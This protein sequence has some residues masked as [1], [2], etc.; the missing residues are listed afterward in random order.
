MLAWIDYYKA[1]EETA[2]RSISYYTKGHLASFCL[3]LELRERSDQ[4]AS[5]QDVMRALWSEY[6]RVGRGIP[7]GAFPGIV[8]R[9]TGV[10]IA[11]FA[12]RYLSGTEELDFDR[13]GRLAGLTFGPIPEK[14]ETLEA[15]LP[16]DLGVDYRIQDNVVRLT[17][18]RDGGPGRRA[19]LSPG[20]ELIAVDGVK[21]VAKEFDDLLKRFPPGTAADLTLFR[22]GWLT[23]VPVTFGRAP[24]EKYQFLPLPE[25]TAR[26]KAIYEAWIGAPW[27]APKA[28]PAK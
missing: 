13:F 8:A 21:I 2:N 11:D 7:E 5:M 12:R 22:R 9:V 26:Q 16:G 28:E 23:R 4:K 25:A 15:G 3:D 1:R 18:V 10:D 17:T 14:P 20:D 27:E 6:G 19:G 24:P